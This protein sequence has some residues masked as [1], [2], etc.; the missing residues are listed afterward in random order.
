MNQIQFTLT[1]PV[2]FSFEGEDTDG[3]FITLTEPSIKQLKYVAAFK[4]AFFQCAEKASSGVDTDSDQVK[5]TGDK[6]KVTSEIIMALL[7]AHYPDMEQLF[8]IAR[9]LFMSIGIAKVEGLSDFNQSV[10]DTMSIDDF[11]NM[12][13]TYLVN[14]IL[15]SALN[16]GS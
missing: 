15:R 9:K 16:L 3:T 5:D 4:K 8:N 14:F 11:E 10:Y 2:K 6:E 12:I 1:T 13:G 7:Y